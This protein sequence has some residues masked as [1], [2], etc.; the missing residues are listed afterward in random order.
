MSKPLAVLMPDGVG[1][2][3]YLH[4][5]C[6]DM[7]QRIDLFHPF[8]EN[9]LHHLELPDNVQPIKLKP[10]QE[11]WK[12][13]L[14][15]ESIHLARLKYN[16]H[17]E[18]NPT[19]L[20]NYMP[21]K[22]GFLSKAFYKIVELVAFYSWKEYDRIQQ[23]EKNYQK[24]IRKNATYKRYLEFFEEKGYEKLFCTH[25]R[26]IIAPYLF[27]AARDLGMHTIT[28]I[29]S[30]DNLPKARMA[31]KA[32]NY[33]VWSEYMKAELQD[34]YPEI[35]K[36]QISVTGTPQ[37]VFH[38]Q[39]KHIWNREDLASYY[40]LD[41]DKKW[42][43][44]SGDDKTTSPYDPD[45]LYDIAHE[46][47]NDQGLKDELQ[48][49]LRPVPTEGFT[50]YEQVIREFSHLIKKTGAAWYEGDRWSDRLP[51]KKDDHILASL[52]KHAFAVVNV[53]STMGLD[54]GIHQKPAIYIN[55]D[56]PDSKKWSV[57]TIYQFQHFRTMGEL[58][59]VYWLNGKKQIR[60]LLYQL[61]R[62]HIKNKEMND[63]IE[64]IIPYKFRE[65]SPEIILEQI[66][67]I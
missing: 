8:K 18:E 31:L 2:R 53:G 45:Y 16:A 35:K 46:I 67:K 3:N 14:L 37:F 36:E 41:M 54:F 43:C 30:W 6:F 12:E 61:G 34:F 65:R 47:A 48:I 32:D 10:F 29:Y 19:I 62:K 23:L 50:K 56:Q 51:Q 13:K 64:K 42:L 9:T 7:D 21:K 59:P 52:C 24:E 17:K 25:Q 40:D 28:A 66:K 39:T 33:F 44:F 1:V 58:E 26:A 38:Y 55:Y 49:L 63:W 5:H 60:D 11:S 20:S 4:T 15:R 22:R 57:K 27:A